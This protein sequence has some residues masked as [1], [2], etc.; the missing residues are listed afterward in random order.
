MQHLTVV[1]TVHNM[2]AFEGELDRA[3]G[4]FDTTLEENDRPWVITAMSPDHEMNRL[5]AIREALEMRVSMSEKLE[6]IRGPAGLRRPG[7]GDCQP[8]IWRPAKLIEQKTPPRP[9]GST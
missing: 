5:Y 9:L 6:I 7:S 8:G 4:L 1:Y 3:R 2:D